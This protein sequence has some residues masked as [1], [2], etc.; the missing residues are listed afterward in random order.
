MSHEIGVTVA[1][2]RK[3]HVVGEEENIEA[4]AAAAAAPGAGADAA[5]IEAAAST[6]SSNVMSTTTWRVVAKS[7]HTR[8]SAALPG[9]KTG[10][11]LRRGVA[12]K[13]C[14]IERKTLRRVEITFLKLA[15]G[16]G[17]LFDREPHARNTVLMKELVKRKQM[18]QVVAA[19]IP[20]EQAKGVDKEKKTMKK[21]KKKKKKKEKKER[22]AVLVEEETT[23]LAEARSEIEALRT[24]HAEEMANQF[25]E[26]A[27]HRDVLE[28]SRAD[29]IAS[30]KAAHA[31][32]LATQRASSEATQRKLKSALAEER[33]VRTLGLANAKAAYLPKLSPAGGKPLTI[34]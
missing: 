12:V 25:L 11:L 26:L 5:E 28:S 10:V 24:E 20:D 19:V 34:E 6:G 32:E 30:I 31:S 13:V 7:I 21:K 2:D 1:D 15:D 4:A 3:V 33:R 16:S 18:M 22:M 29:A 8:R 17:W 14:D 27:Q 9:A 23:A